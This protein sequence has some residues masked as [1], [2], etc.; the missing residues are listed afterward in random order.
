MIC[1]CFVTHFTFFGFI[2]QCF[3]RAL[4]EGGKEQPTTVPTAL[5]ST[6][7]SFV[8]MSGIFLHS[9]IEAKTISVSPMHE[10]FPTMIF[11]ICMNCVQNYK[12]D[13]QITTTTSK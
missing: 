13:V 6:D 1:C 11:K 2:E 12:N 3:F 10:N 4:S 8:G 7:S 9:I 5:S